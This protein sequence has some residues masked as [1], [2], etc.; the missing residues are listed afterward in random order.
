[1]TAPADLVLTNAEV[2]TLTDPDETA[3]AVAVRDGDIVRVDRAEEVR[4]LEGVATR[5][6]DLAGRVVLPGFVDGHTHLE[7]VGRRTI[8]AD[9]SDAASPADCRDR[10]EATATDDAGAEDWI[11][12]F[13]YDEGNWDGDL[14]ATDDLD[15][16][17]TDRPVAA[18]REDLHTVS[19]NSVA[20]DSLGDLPDR[21]VRTEGGEPTGVLVEEA[22]NA[23]FDAINPDP[24]QLREYLLAAQDVA[25]SR[26]V[27]AV[28]EMVRNSHA[29]RVYRD[30]ALS[31]DLDLR[32][33]LNYWAD[34][35]DA[36][37]ETGLRTNHG[38]ELVQVGGIKSFTDGS[39]GGHT[40]KLR[41]PYADDPET[42]GEWVVDPDE[43]HDVVE[44]ADE[45]GLQVTLHAIGDAAIDVALDAFEDAD[46]ERHRIEHLEVLPDDLLERLADSDVVAS[47]QPNFLK[48]A[49]EGGLY[50]ERLGEARRQ[51]TD[52]IGDLHDAG[53]SLAFGSDCMPIGP[54]FG[55]ARVVDAPEPG[56]SLPVTEA[57]RAYT[58]G[59]AAAGYD[60]DR[61]GTVEPG[62]CADF[63]V[64]DTSPW[65]VADV[66]GVDVALTVVDGDVV[67][68]GR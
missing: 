7:M 36:V 1:M 10:L 56:Q 22:A 13:G 9:L 48:W 34:H 60:E 21:D 33:R 63:T 15:P 19:V 30:L 16:V 67:Y 5:V 29:P 65:E 23:V 50:T 26:G 45:A 61:L 64:L 20:L 53:V 68:D 49:E 46:G 54:L 62:T 57:L 25:V 51:V 8:E 27:T 44:R 47:V 4:M 35:L 39:I 18:F 42:E 32:V 17:S 14:L 55:I 37:V 41:E 40:A 66:T 6:L 28:H 58:S 24:D 2:H 38:S 11:L 52:R 43:I 31:G 12:G 59:A 3:E